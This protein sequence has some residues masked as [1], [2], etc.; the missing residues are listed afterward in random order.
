MSPIACVNLH[1]KSLK[2]KQFW[3]LLQKEL[4]SIIVKLQNNCKDHLQIVCIALHSI[5]H[6]VHV[7]QCEYYA[8]RAR[9]SQDGT[10]HLIDKPLN[11][12]FLGMT[13]IIA[14]RPS[15]SNTK[16]MCYMSFHTF[17]P[18]QCT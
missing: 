8:P 10:A 18:F 7:C 16:L 2:G 9:G 11:Q 15:K 13:P 6:H 14:I 12:V 3:A 17:E 5:M 1:G 4:Q